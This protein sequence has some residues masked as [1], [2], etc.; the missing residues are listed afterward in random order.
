MHREPR[1]RTFQNVELFPTMTVLENVLVGAHTVSRFEQERVVRAR[2]Q[3]TLDYVGIGDVARRPAAG[4]P[5]YLKRVWRA[6]S[7]ESRACGHST[8]LRAA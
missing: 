6:H 1:T 2:A 7:S 5:L 4:L 8:S 3:E